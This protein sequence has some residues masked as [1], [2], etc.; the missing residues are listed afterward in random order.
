METPVDIAAE[1]IDALREYL[2]WCLKSLDQPMLE[3]G[4]IEFQSDGFDD[5]SNGDDEDEISEEDK[6]SDNLERLA[7]SIK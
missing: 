1:S 2:E 3:V 5:F 4:K 7:E 6:D